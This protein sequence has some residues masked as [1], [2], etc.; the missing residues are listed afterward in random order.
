M[1]T[2]RQALELATVGGARILGRD[3]IGRIAPGF[4]ADLIAL[5]L[6]RIEFAGALHDPVAAIVLCGPSSVD[7]S[8]V[9]GRPLVQDRRVSGVELGSLVDE[10]NRLSRTLIG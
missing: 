7:H 1:M 3:D 10:H 8:W 2:P 5:D 6:N 4:V 9:G